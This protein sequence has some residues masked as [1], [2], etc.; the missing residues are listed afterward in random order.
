M[1][2]SSIYGWYFNRP[3]DMPESVWRVLRTMVQFIIA[4]FAVYLSQYCVT[5]EFNMAD[6]WFSIIVPAVVIGLSMIGK[7]ANDELCVD[8]GE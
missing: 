1:N 4:E 8:E 2:M 6:L 3:A 5:R 7:S